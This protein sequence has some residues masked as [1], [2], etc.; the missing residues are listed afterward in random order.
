MEQI[1]NSMS[2]NCISHEARQELC[3]H[4]LLKLQLPLGQMRNST[5]NVDRNQKHTIPM[6]CW[7][8]QASMKMIQPFRNTNRDLVYNSPSVRVTVPICQ[9]ESS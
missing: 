4:W 1:C 2:K 6:D 7:L 5:V 9:A 8:L 3:S